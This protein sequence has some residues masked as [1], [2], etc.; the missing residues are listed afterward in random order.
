MFSPNDH[1]LTH[2]LK[3]IHLISLFLEVASYVFR[4]EIHFS[5]HNLGHLLNHFVLKGQML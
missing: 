5:R 2:W 4:F 3:N 1:P